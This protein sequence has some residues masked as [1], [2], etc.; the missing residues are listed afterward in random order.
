MQ[1]ISQLVALQ[2]KYKSL[3]ES[4]LSLSFLQLANMILP[5][6][7]L[8]YLIKILGVDNYG[9]YVFAYSVCNYFNTI[10][11][12]GFR[13]NGTRDVAL[14][15]NNP[16][17]LSAIISKILYSKFLLTIIS[18]VILSATLPLFNKYNQSYSI[19]YFSFLVVLFTSLFPDWFFQ[20]MEKMRFI[21]ILNLV[22]KLL[23]TIA[24]FIFIKSPG[25]YILV[26]LIG[27]IGAFVAMT[28]AWWIILVQMK[29]KFIRQR[30]SG[31]IIAIKESTPLF[32]NNLFPILYNNT[33]SFLLGMFGTPAQLAYFGAAQRIVE[34]IGTTAIRI[35]S[36]T[37]FPYLNVQKGQSKAVGKIFFFSGLILSVF[38][39]IFA[40]LIVKYL[41]TEDFNQ[42]VWLIR[43]M[44][45]SVLFYAINDNYGTNYLLINRKDK[46]LM[47]ISMVVSFIGL[48]IAFPL[49]FFFKHW[50]A[51]FTILFSRMLFASV[52]YY[53]A[54]KIELST[55]SN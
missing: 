4:I 14:N 6:I 7:T 42:S 37:F 5:L 25:D 21:T 55:K 12:Y 3:S 20:G 26:P 8:P 54:K 51:A 30:T 49:I 11:D 38:F 50:G 39:I 44:G 28:G 47:R 24:I 23:F 9:I 27:A 45:L 46:L 18:I 48:S 31:I 15:R 43:I 34:A 16:K 53:F 2:K 1:F 52:V 36:Q 40:P 10:I 41:F 35:L 17:A 19:F 29:L 22:S 33:S 13:L 32:L